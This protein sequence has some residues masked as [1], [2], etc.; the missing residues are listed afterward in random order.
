MKK[1]I[2]RLFAGPRPPPDFTIYQR[3]E[4]DLDVPKAVRQDDPFPLIEDS[5]YRRP[6]ASFLVGSCSFVLGSW[7]SID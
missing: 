5:C 2:G 1:V 6:L 4:S 7:C 3:A